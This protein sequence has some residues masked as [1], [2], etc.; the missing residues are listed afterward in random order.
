[1]SL[2]ERKMRIQNFNITMPR[3]KLSDAER[4]QPLGLVKAGITYRRVGENLNCFKINQLMICYNE[5]RY[6]QI[7]K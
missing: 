7:K 5:F 3:R 2:T 6:A 4:W 1:M